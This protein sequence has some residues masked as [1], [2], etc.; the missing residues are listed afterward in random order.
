MDVDKN[1]TAESFTGV[2][3]GALSSSEQIAD[4]ISGSFTA[5]SGGLS[6]RITTVEG[7]VGGQA[8]NST[9]SPTFAGLTTTGDVEVQGTLTA[10]ELI[11]SS[12]VTN[13]TV[14]EK[15]GSTIF[16][17]YNTDTHQFTGSILIDGGKI[18]PSTIS[19]SLGSNASVIRTLTKAGIS[20]SLGPNADEIRL[21]NK[22]SISGSLSK[23]HLSSKV[24]N[25]VSASVLSS[26]A[27]GTITLTTNGVG[28]DVDSGLQVGDSPTFVTTTLSGLT[29]NKIVRTDG[30]KVIG[31]ADINDFITGT[32]NQIT[33]TDDTDGTITLSTPQN[34]HTSATPTFASLTTTG[35]VEVQ[36][37]LT[38]QEL[39]VSSS[40]TNM[41]VAQKSGSTVFGDDNSDTHLSLIHI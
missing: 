7:N 2:F 17:D 19:G 29:A 22:A 8:V 28:N 5:V 11:V 21:L 13:I 24:P 25:I 35:D 31:S 32:T 33:V 37:T 27:Q 40:V 14:A 23:N 39:I 20:G 4:S 16:V 3:E 18:S 38:A 1:I 36:G 26:G 6:T 12:S 41:V 34:L 30:S 10:Q 15:S 9:D